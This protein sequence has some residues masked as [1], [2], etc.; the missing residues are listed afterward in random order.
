MADEAKLR[1]Y[2]KRT[3]ADL[4]ATRRRLRT[5][6]AR[7]HEPLAIVGMSCRFPGGVRSPQELW[8]LVAAGEDA[9]SPFPTDRGWDLEALYDPDVARAGTSYVREG[10]FIDGVGDFDAAFFG[11]SPR[12]ALAMDPQQRLLLETSWEALEDADIDPT[13]LRGSRTGVFTGVAESNYGAGR[14]SSSKELQGYWLT[15]GTGSVASGRVAYVLGLEGP[16]VSVDTACS[17]SLVALHFAC[18]ALRRGECTL[19]LAG[20]ASVMVGPRM[21]VE[22][23]HQRGLASDGRCK[24]FAQAADGTGWGEGVGVVVLERLEDARR[25]GH[26]VLAVVRGSAVNQDGASNGLTAPNGPSQQRVIHQALLDAQLSEGDVDAVEAH[27]TGTVLGDPIEAQALL[28]TYGQ[29]RTQARPLWLGSIKSNIG[30][31]MCAA[32]VAGVIKMTMALQHEVLPQTLHVDS[33]SAQ[34]D[35]SAGAVS[36]LREPVPWPRNGEGSQNTRRRAAV[37]SFGISGT[38]AHVILEVAPVEDGEAPAQDEVAPVEDGVAPVEDGVAPVEDGVAPVEDGVAPVEDGVAPVEDGVA[39]VEDGVAPVEDGVAPVEDGVAPVED[40]VAPVE[41]GVAPVEDGVAPVEDGVAPV[42][43]GVAPVEDGVAPVEDEEAPARD[44][45]APAHEDPA[46]AADNSALGAV[47]IPWVVSAK[48]ERALRAQA[49]RMLGFLEGAPEASP[50]DVGRSLLNRAALEHRGVVVGGEREELLAGL[51]ALARGESSAGVVEGAADLDG[52]VVFVF[53][54]HGSQWEGMAVEL[55]DRSAVFAEAVRECG[56]ALAEFVDWSV[57]G[58]LRGAPG[59]P[60]LERI[61]V[62]QPVLFAVMVSLA[63]LW[64]ACGVRP[65]AVVGH[66]QGEVAAA[67]VAGGL[68]LRD[69]ARVVAVRSR[70]LSGLTGHGGV[71][72][73]AQGV[74]QVRE[75]LRRWGGRLV[76]A[77]VNG[78]RSVGVAGER[79]ALLEFLEECAAEEWRAREV[80]GATAAGH[81]QYVEVYREEVLEV[82]AQVAPRAGEVSF[83]ST[84]TGGLLDTA[85]LDA[86]YWYRNLRETV[87]FE[88]VTRALLGEGY[89]TFIEVSP[90]P[91]LSVGI[92]ETAEEALA[93]RVPA[94]GAPPEGAQGRDDSP[95][96]RAFAAPSVA[97]IGSLR[98][99]EGGPRRFFASL[100]E[101]WVRGVAVDF[102]PLFAGGP[103]RRVGLPKYAFQ[104]ERYWLAA[105]AGAGDLAAAG[106]ASAEHPLLG[107]RVALAERDGWLFTGR[108]SLQSHA[109]LADHAARG[110]VLLPGTAFVELALH[111]GAQVGCELVQELTLEEPMVLGEGE[112]VQVQLTVGAPDQA[113]CRAVEV[114][115]RVTDGAAEGVLAGEGWTRNAGGTLAPGAALTAGGTLAPEGTLAAGGAGDRDGRV[116]AGLGGDLDGLNGGLGGSGSDLDG[117]GGVLAGAVWP[118]AGA[119][120]VAVADLYER[121]AAGGFDYG[122]EFR[123]LRGVWRRGEDLFAEVSLSEEQRVQGQSFGL[124]PALLDAALHALAA[125]GLGEPGGAP[126]GPRLPF[127]W[128]GVSLHATGASALRV[129]LSPTGGG[130]VSLKAAD[131]AGAGVLSAHSL[132]L[133]PISAEQLGRMRRDAPQQVLCVEWAPVSRGPAVAGDRLVLLE[134]RDGAL[135][136]ALRAAAVEFEVYEDLASLGGA[137]QEV[138]AAPRVVLVDA[139][140][141][142]RGGVVDAVHA[143]THEALRVA[144][145]WLAE[146]RLAACR[147]A[148][149]TGGAVAVGAEEGLPGL[150]QA[151]VWGLVRVAQAENPGRFA[152]VDL[153]GAQTSWEALPEALLAS[154]T[155]EHQLAIREGG[156]FAPR[157]A[158]VAP[159][160]ALRGGAGEGGSVDGAEGGPVGEV[161]EGGPVGEDAARGGPA[162]E[163]DGTVL[164]TGGTG[165]LGALL[166]R[167][168]VVAHG[169]RHLLLTS[170]QGPQAPGAAELQAELGERGA[171][172]RVAACDVADREQLRTL[173]ASVSQEHPLRAVVHAAGVLDD[174]VVGSLTAERID[175]VLAPKVDGAWHLHELTEHTELSAFV[176]FSSLAGVLGGSGQGN[177]AAANTFLDALAAAR[178]AC[179]LTGCSIAWGPWEQT[180][181]MASTLREVD[182]VRIARSGVVPLSA[183]EG[184]EMFDAA[185]ALG[186]P[187]VVAAR[188]NRAVLRGFAEAGALPSVWR[189]LVRAPLRRGAGTERGSLARR[190]ASA[191]THERP[192]IVLDTVRAHAAT[193]LGHAS[194]A[195][196]EARQ[197]FKELGFDSLAAVE[198]RNRL[199]AAAELNLPATLVFDYPT[200]ALVAEHLVGVLASGAATAGVSVEAEMVELERRLSAIATDETARA[201]LTVRL[202]AFLAG[203]NG[204]QATAEDDEDVRSATVEDVFELIDRELGALE[205]AGGGDGA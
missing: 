19:A 141:W 71:A 144:Q 156:V 191:S 76:V 58:V 114:Y 160:G 89:R 70:M 24:S 55:L 33:P 72:S 155:E 23:S 26:R 6:E 16:A 86:G 201:R 30:H 59:A 79:E 113:G 115:S 97:A 95:S 142:V 4:R 68:S 3:T 172:V 122:P 2:L 186:E 135:A 102:R 151:G 194:P 178:R 169:V 116:R 167:H 99:G 90:H 105:Q 152:L 153:D 94:E 140:E 204:G 162:L 159:A 203:L 8:E 190:L 130:G 136:G 77:G 42:E 1:E 205:G 170:R 36:L 20:G 81:T 15:G 185:H 168:L 121:L 196:I 9:I 110:V 189:G 192:R 47:V 187:L 78:P 127:A 157:L 44:G 107:A 54:G 62:V 126:G 80:P 57:E 31:T 21:F 7:G 195:A 53:A 200:P 202:G 134:E 177:Y 12:E 14:W 17:S 176:L 143:S 163:V 25:H 132:A 184:L 96:A 50:R 51:G 183:A 150:A 112:E 173:L 43:D 125:T 131:G 40:G 91:V 133:R 164:L 137:V 171:S 11:I 198:F 75:R 52:G 109:W 63:R 128:G 84:V 46:P 103:T 104:R 193:V 5:V 174:G 98:R 129:H 60:A 139:R 197:P 100:A 101:A 165:E 37:S 118:P 74:E 64:G 65:T 41:D 27:G 111:A 13:S 161:A 34:V 149:V 180:G 48:D 146:E 106:Q 87:E 175:G 120:E 92:Q 29:R 138:A 56:E 182:R 28:A 147:L 73:V 38:N 66:S 10:G 39:P 181:G 35:W 83:Y 69:A 166:A 45:E 88:R 124:H 188:L 85:E 32:G 119:V 93:E 148:V 108:L 145:A 158:P 18:Q 67:H 61:D 49:G 82:L 117:S 199:S 179:G 22:I 154:G 123:C